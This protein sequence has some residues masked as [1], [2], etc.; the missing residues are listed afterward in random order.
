MNSMTPI[1]QRL[2]D[3]KHLRRSEVEDLTG[4][5]RSSIYRLMSTGDFP[6]PSRLT[7]KA[8]RWRLSEISAWLAERAPV[9]A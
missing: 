9:A 2:V 3:E 5:S 1:M 8:V 4:L 6:K 7:G